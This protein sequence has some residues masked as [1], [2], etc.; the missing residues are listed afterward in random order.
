MV[1]ETLCELDSSCTTE[2]I[3]T[4]TYINISLRSGQVEDDVFKGEKV[5][6]VFSSS[7]FINKAQHHHHHHFL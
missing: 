6:E 3:R 1:I 4:K 2:G 7:S 5:T